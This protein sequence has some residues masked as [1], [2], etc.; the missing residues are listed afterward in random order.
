MLKNAKEGI[1]SAYA[2][3]EYPLTQA[4]NAYLE[5][6]KA[7]N[8]SF[9]RLG[10][11][12]GLYFPELKI[13]SPKM[14]ADL[15]IALNDVKEVSREKIAEVMKDDKRTDE[16]YG[17][18]VATMGRR[19]TERERDAVVG[20]AK[21]SN[22]IAS[23]LD[24][25]DAY[26]KKVS[27]E[28]MPN[29]VYLTDEKIAAE[30]LSKA[31]SLERLATLPAS[32]I[33]L[34]G[35]EKSLFKHIKFGSKPP[36]YGLIFKMPEISGAP[37]DQRGRIARVYAAKICMALKSDYFTKNFIAE[38]LKAD[39]KTSIERINSS[40][41]RIRE[42]RPWK[43]PRQSWGGR[44]RQQRSEPRQWVRERPQSRG[45]KPW[46][47]GPR[48]PWAQKSERNERKNYKRKA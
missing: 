23:T 20:F 21:L 16:T 35:A 19:M 9:E 12:Y 36:K 5:I 15:A 30:L 31:G 13:T 48:R 43:G 41:P 7:Y 6:S 1:H 26:I 3:E 25:L 27:T 46:E 39:L 33:Q 28:I 24:V 29:T 11:W 44:Q 42:N 40:E 18:A 37:K 4:I 10:E 2:N 32:T 17:K 38:K 47:R 34:L 8:L 45:Q 22:E 14:L